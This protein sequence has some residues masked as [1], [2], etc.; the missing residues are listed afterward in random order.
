GRRDHPAA[1]AALLREMGFAA[2]APLAASHVDITI[3][4]EAPLSEAELVHLADKLVE[5]DRRVDLGGRFQA[6]LERNGRDPG[7][8]EAIQRR[9][10][11]ARLISRRVEAAL[12]MGL[13]DFLAQA[14]LP[15]GAKAS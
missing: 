3:A 6:K 1:G 7:A 10:D 5:G 13:E 8:L 15:V 14:Q 4:P 9:W 11:L 2:V 12:G